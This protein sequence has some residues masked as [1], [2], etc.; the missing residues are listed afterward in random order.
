[1]IPTWDEVRNWNTNGVE[2]WSH[3]TDH[4]DYRSKDYKGLY[5]ERV[6]SKAEIKGQNIKHGVTN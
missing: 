3:G 6:T 5:S 2:I 4:K 1:M